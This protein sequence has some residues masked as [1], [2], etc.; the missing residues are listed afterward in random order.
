L[1]AGVYSGF[2]EQRHPARGLRAILHRQRRWIENRNGSGTGD[3][4]Y[5]IYRDPSGLAVFAYELKVERS[6]DGTQ[7]RAS[8]LP[9][10][11]D[12]AAKFPNADGGK[13][14]PTLSEVHRSPLLDSGGNSQSTFP[15][16]PGYK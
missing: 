4:F 15:R 11:D 12:F 7:F 16:T 3:S 14:T 9:A 10:E 1:G 8:A 2:A 13:P 5:R 6:S